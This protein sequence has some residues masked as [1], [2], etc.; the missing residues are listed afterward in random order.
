MLVTV[1]KQADLR[2]Q[3]ELEFFILAIHD[4]WEIDLG[5]YMF[6]PQYDRGF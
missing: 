5:K 4:N 1:G 6:K 2:G 3:N